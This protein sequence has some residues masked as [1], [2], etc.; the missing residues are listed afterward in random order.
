M[1]LPVPLRVTATVFAWLL[2]LLAAAAPA[3]YTGSAPVNSQS[4]TERAGA[5]RTA[6]ANVVIEQTADSGIMARADVARAVEKA[7]RYVLQYSYRR[8]P[9]GDAPL[10]LEASFDADAVDRM[11]QGLGLGRLAGVPLAGTTPSEATVWIGDIRDADDYARV[12][13]YL[14]RSNFVKDARPVAAT[15][16]G[17]LVHLSLSTALERFLDAVAMERQLAT[18]DT[19]VDGADAALALA[20]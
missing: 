5:L 2:P 16:D 1:R 7:E 3:T 12:I 18:T 4:D 19:R 10:A 11:L 13:A 20:H 14:G 17:I 15:A 8:T 9:A 6:L